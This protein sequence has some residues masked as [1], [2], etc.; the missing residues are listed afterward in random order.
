MDGGYILV[1]LSSSLR[2]NLRTPASRANVPAGLETDSYRIQ[3][4]TSSVL[5]R[6]DN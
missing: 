4:S 2:I 3:V 1:D 6:L 5:R